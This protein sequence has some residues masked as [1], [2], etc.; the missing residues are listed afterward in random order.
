MEEYEMPEEQE[1]ELVEVEEFEEDVEE[2]F[3]PVFS[4]NDIDMKTFGKYK[5]LRFW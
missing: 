1:E 3:H 4:D 2:D 5:E